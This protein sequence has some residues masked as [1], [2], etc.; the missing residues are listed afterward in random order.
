MQ[1]LINENINN[2]NIFKITTQLFISLLCLL[3]FGRHGR[4]GV[5]ALEV[6]P[7]RF[8]VGD[9][10]TAHG[11]GE[12]QRGLGGSFGL[13]SAPALLSLL[14]LA[15]VFLLGLNLLLTACHCS[16]VW[17]EPRRVTAVESGGYYGSHGR[18]L[19]LP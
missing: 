9:L 7:V 16:Q 10:R 11:T 13:F 17:T 6:L 5:F 4:L 2:C 3:E 15:L 19:C 1:E 14:L 18:E 8:D 12:H